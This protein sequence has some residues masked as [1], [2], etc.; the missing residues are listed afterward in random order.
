VRWLGR[1]RAAELGHAVSAA[2]A[3]LPAA[4]LAV[5]GQAL[6]DA[7]AYRA[8]GGCE[9]CRAGV[10]CADHEDDAARRAS[11]LALGELLGL[12]VDP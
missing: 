7:A 4:Q 11:Y 10:P 5:L 3:V 2:P 12:D 8:P 1:G 6:A 9:D